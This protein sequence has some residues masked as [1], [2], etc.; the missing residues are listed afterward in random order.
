MRAIAIPK[1]PLAPQNTEP[2]KTKAQSCGREEVWPFQEDG[3]GGSC[4]EV[5]GKGAFWVPAGGVGR[6]RL[7]T[8]RG[9][10]LVPSASTTPD[11]S[12]TCPQ[13]LLWKPG[14]IQHQAGFFGRKEKGEKVV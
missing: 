14:H 11:V 4:G 3:L 9:Q 5:N 12:V 2:F 13:V 10:P 7:G 8:L 6:Y 1:Q